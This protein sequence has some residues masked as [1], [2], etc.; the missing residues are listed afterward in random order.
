MATRVAAGHQ[1][2]QQLQPLG[3]QL[4][5]E[6]IDARQIAARP[7]EAGDKSELDR[8][9][10]DAED[11][12][13]RR[14]GRL[15]R[16]RRGEASAD[17]HRDPAADQIGRQRRQPNELILGPAVDDR[18]VLALDKPASLRPWR[19]RANGPQYASGDLAS[20]N[21][22]TGIAGCCARAASGH[23]ALRRRELD[24]LAPPHCLP[25]SGQ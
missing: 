5:D 17:D 15:G 2:A 4:G 1:L 20:R 10:A 24:E 8:V 7:G 25:P 22:T 11:D 9:L 14:G 21:P 6:K 16:K 18:D 12:R 13:D 23:A 19:N 3:R